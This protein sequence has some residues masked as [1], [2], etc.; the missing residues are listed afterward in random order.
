MHRRAKSPGIRARPVTAPRPPLQCTDRRL[1]RTEQVL[2]SQTEQG[3]KSA[4][5]NPW[6]DCIACSS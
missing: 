6:G 3:V 2:E 4:I 1:S 5:D